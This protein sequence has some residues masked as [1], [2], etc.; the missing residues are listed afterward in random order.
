V[1]QR[2]QISVRRIRTE[3]VL[4]YRRLSPTGRVSVGLLSATGLNACPPDKRK[5]IIFNYRLTDRPH[6]GKW[7]R[8]PAA[9][10]DLRLYKSPCPWLQIQVSLEKRLLRAKGREAEGPHGNISEENGK[11]RQESFQN[12]A[13]KPERGRFAQPL[14]PAR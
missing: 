5:S 14:I 1:L 8:R 13:R 9:L 6:L 12:G 2:V 3:P 10:E 11:R 7:H 4:R